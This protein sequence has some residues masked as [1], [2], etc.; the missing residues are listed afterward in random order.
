M[1]HYCVAKLT[2]KEKGLQKRLYSGGLKRGVALW[3]IA[4]SALSCF[5]TAA[6]SQD[7]SKTAPLKVLRMAFSTAETGFDPPRVSDLYSNT[8]NE[9]IFERLLTYDYLARPARLAPMTAVALPE[10]TDGGKTYT[11]RLRHGIF[12]TPDPA[13]GGKPRELTA[14]DYVY[15]F[16]RVLDPK[17]RSPWAFLLEGRI[18]GLDAL[19]EAAKKTGKFDY[20]TEIE[21]LK[22]SDRYTLQVRLSEPD[23]NFNYVA[24]HTPFSAM[25]R[26]VVEKYGEDTMAHPIGTGP[27][28]LKQWTRGARIVLEKNPDYRGMIWN[29]AASEEG[30]AELISEMQGK[31]LPLI[32]RVEISIIEEEQSA[33]LAFDRKELDFSGVGTFREK[34]FDEKGELK[35]EWRAQGVKLM[36][37]ID[38]EVTYTFFNFR[39]PIVGGF[40]KEKLALR[41]AIIMAYNRDEEIDVIRKGQAIP[42]TMPIPVGVVGHDPRYQPLN[43]YNPALANQLLDAFGFKKGKDGFRT[44]PNGAPLLLKYATGTT[45]LERQFNELWKKA[46]DS[47]SVRIAFQPGKFADLIKASMACQLQMWGSAWTADY[48][49]GDNFMQLL[50]GPNIGQNN[51]GCYESKAFDAFYEASLKLPDSPER[52][53]L[54]LEMTRQ[55]EVDGAWVLGVSRERN[56]LIRPWV[57]GY[58][59]HPI[60]SA[61]WIYLDIDPAKKP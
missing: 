53:R 25:A 35:P 31:R 55:M 32:D 47:I 52:N 49:D 14:A 23:Y 38:P 7:A 57:I 45:A 15:S 8:I 37:A 22:A 29:F 10:I 17:I 42:A 3:F 11:F 44:M 24:A 40:E 9:A 4:A 50:Y 36:R 6:L 59:K 61:T 56:M 26:E 5:S 21:G 30:D 48:P 16:K 2:G 1:V 19:A 51:H 20:D 39:D 13:F 12:F 54:F 43:T 27:Y 34:V 46:M 41:R 28:V 60:L 33:W 58:K 18:I